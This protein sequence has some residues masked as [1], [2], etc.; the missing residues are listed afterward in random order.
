[1]LPHYLITKLLFGVDPAASCNCNGCVYLISIHLSFWYQLFNIF[2][3]HHFSPTLSSCGLGV[4]PQTGAK[5][6]WFYP[7]VDIVSGP[8]SGWVS[9][10]VQKLQN[11][12]QNFFLNLLLLGWMWLILWGFHHSGRQAG[13]ACGESRKES[14]SEK[15]HQGLSDLAWLPAST[16]P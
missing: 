6:W 3:E 1:M 12:P 5:Q 11:W 8:G 4:E 14:G 2:L 9:D 16:W 15:P 13:A 7:H 10:P